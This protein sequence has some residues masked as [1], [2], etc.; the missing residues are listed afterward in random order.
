MDVLTVIIQNTAL[1]GMPKWYQALTLTL[2]AI[3]A[4]L[5]ISMYFRIA[6]QASEMSEMAMRFGY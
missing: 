6:L 3:I 4:T 2:F 5:A 1:N